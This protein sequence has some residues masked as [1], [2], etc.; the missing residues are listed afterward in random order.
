[1]FKWL[2]FE[3]LIPLIFIVGVAQYGGAAGT[4]ALQ[5][6]GALWQMDNATMEGAGISRYVKDG[7]LLILSISWPIYIK[8][9]GLPRATTNLVG[10]YF[11]WVVLAISLGLIGAIFGDGSWIFIFAGLRWLMLLHASFGVF[12]MT[13]SL[14]DKMGKHKSVI[15]CL[16][17]LALLD[18]V[19]VMW[20]LRSGQ[21]AFG[22]SFGQ[23]RLTGLF[24]NAGVAGFFGLALAL[25]G[26]QLDGAS[27]K[28]RLVLSSA[29]LVIALSTG[30]RSMIIGVFLVMMV[31]VLE[32]VESGS[33]RGIKDALMILL[34]PI[35]GVVAWVGYGWMIQ[36][37]DRGDIVEM[38]LANG[39]RI[40][41]FVGMVDVLS[42]AEQIEFM[43]GRGLGIGTNTA[44][45][46]L[47][48]SGISPEGIRFNW[49]IDN[50]FLT[51]FFQFGLIGSLVFWV[52]VLFFAVTIRPGKY[53]RYRRRYL[54]AAVMF[55]VILWAGNP[56]EH[57]F[58]MLPFAIAM[59]S[60]YWG[61]MAQG[62]RNFVKLT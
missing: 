12:L 11:I 5:G 35:L 57:Y 29:A 33:R 45:S 19:V 16:I 20:Q 4:S 50:A 52:G 23:G 15:Y 41:N 48:A 22:V 39:G 59:G 37:V 55:F 44:Y 38:Q 21:A 6:D 43:F 47:A 58:L 32:G 49:L 61:G 13:Y 51:Q 34:I 54:I 36:T 14:P 40:S 46:M 10:I 62:R 9:L 7:F 56:F 26:L 17:L 3:I 28:S 27:R 18:L 1:M 2:R 24:N 25:T 53:K 31:Q 30:T 60:V 8:K 42:T